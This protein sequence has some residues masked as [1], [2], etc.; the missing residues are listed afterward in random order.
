M[1]ENQPIAENH[2]PNNAEI[3]NQE[4]QAN[5]KFMVPTCANYIHRYTCIKHDEYIDTWTMDQPPSVMARPRFET[6]SWVPGKLDLVTHQGTAVDP[7]SH[8]SCDQ[9]PHGARQSR[10]GTR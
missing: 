7:L 5:I 10:L 6:V 4:L 3:S 8:L 2:Q 1:V 9:E